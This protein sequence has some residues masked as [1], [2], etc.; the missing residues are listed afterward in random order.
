MLHELFVIKRCCA[1]QVKRKIYAHS[2]MIM[3]D[4]LN[5]IMGIGQ[6]SSNQG[7]SVVNMRML[8]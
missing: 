1:S 2:H 5:G 8:H 7:F 6:H 3:N 4:L